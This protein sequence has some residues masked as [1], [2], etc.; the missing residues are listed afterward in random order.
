[1]EIE[2]TAKRINMFVDF[3]DADLERIAEIGRRYPDDM[4]GRGRGGGLSSGIRQ[5]INIM[6]NMSPAELEQHLG[7]GQF[8]PEDGITTPS[9]Y[10]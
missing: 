5:A 2:A 10:S 9:K 4:C 3:S 6:L 1:M 7:N 8:L